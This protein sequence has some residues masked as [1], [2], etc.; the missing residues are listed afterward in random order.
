[1]REVRAGPPPER[2]D[3]ALAPPVLIRATGLQI[4]LGKVRPLT[5]PGRGPSTDSDHCSR[6]EHARSDC[7][8]PWPPRGPSG[9]PR[10]PSPSPDTAAAF[11]VGGGSPRLRAR[12]CHAA[13]TG[14][15]C[16]TWRMR[17]GQRS[18][19]Y[20]ARRESERPPDTTFPQVRGPFVMVAGEGFEPS[21]LS[22]RIYSP[23]PLAARTTCLGAHGR[24]A[25]TPT[26]TKTR[27]I[28]H[29]RR[30]LRHRQQDR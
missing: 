22:R 23:L 11:H 13:A 2:R 30:L 20:L 15:G 5:S 29:G 27:F 1:M 6:L 18:G 14:P 21:K 24:I 8:R 3:P 4:F 7:R 10:C 12:T 28:S 16:S 17:H 19:T 25:R 9:R 26:A